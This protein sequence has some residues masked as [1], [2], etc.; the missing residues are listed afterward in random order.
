MAETRDTL[1]AEH[2]YLVEMVADKLKRQYTLLMSIE[3]LRAYGTQG[4]LEA[5][6]RFDPTRGASFSTF[7]YYRVRGAIIDGMRI[8][9]WYSRGDYARYRAEERANEYL[10]NLAE[11]DAEGQP[12]VLTSKSQV[13]EDIAKTLDGL[14]TIHVATLDSV[15]DMP[16]LE[17]ESA[18]DRLEKKEASS[19]VRAALATLPEKERQLMELYYYGGKNLTEAGAV[20]GL[21]KSWVCRLHA[22][23]VNL[24]RDALEDLS[25]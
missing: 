10:S 20:L 6:K 1:I 17:G 23:A 13:L 9:G 12:V 21:S 22:R 25:D 24:L 8:S 3:D 15:G 19:A 7:A 18:E 4:L 11:R 16:D 5:A 14:V 2:M